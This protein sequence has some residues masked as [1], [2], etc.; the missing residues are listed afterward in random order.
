MQSSIEKIGKALFAH[1]KAQSSGLNIFKLQNLKDFLLKFSIAQP[2]LKQKLFHFVDVLPVLKTKEQKSRF[3][4]EYLLPYL[5]QFIYKNKFFAQTLDLGIGLAV[6]VMARSFICGSNLSQAKAKIKNL[7]DQGLDYTIDILGELALTQVEAD[8]Y[9]NDYIELIEGLEQASISV[10]LSAL[11]P[12]VN[13]LDYS[14]K[15]S[16][17]KKLLREIYRKATEHHCSITVDTEH[18]SWKEMTYELIQELL[19]EDEFRDWQGAGIVLQAYLRESKKDFR[20]WLSWVKKRGTPIKVRLVKGAYWDS[21]YALAKQNGFEIPVWEHKV[22]SD[23]NYEELTRELLLNRHYLRPAI[24][25]H[26]IR[27]LAHALDFASE[28]KIKP[29]E[30]E[31]QMLYGMLDPIKQYLVAHGYQC[32]V[33]MPYGELVPGMSY[34][35][36]RLLENTAN[37]S[38]LRQGFLEHAQIDKLLQDPHRVKFETK[39]DEHEFVNSSNIDFSQK[40]N[41]QKFEQA[42]EKVQVQRF[43]IFESHLDDCDRAIAAAIEIAADWN[44]AKPELRA[45]VLQEAAKALE[46]ERFRFSALICL[47]VHKP[48]QEADREVSETIDFLNYYALSSLALHNQDDLISLPGEKNTNQYQAYGPALVVSPWNFPLAL[49]AGMSS[50]ALVMGNP[51]IIKASQ[52]SKCVAH[53]FVSLMQVA[54]MKHASHYGDGLFQLIQGDGRKLGSYL[55]EH[56]AIR[57]IAFTGSNQVGMRLSDIANK[58]RPAKAMIAEMGGKNAIIVDASADPDEV[59]PGVLYSAFAFAGQKCSAC[60]RLIVE[61]AIYDEFRDRLVEAAKSINLREAWDEA[62]SLGP[63]I[64]DKAYKEIMSYIKLAERD[65]KSLLEPKKMPANFISPRIFEGLGPDHKVVQEEIFGPVLVLL[66]ARDIDHALELANNS[67]YGLTGGIYSRSPKNIAKVKQEFQVGNLYI[68]R[69]CTGAVVARQAFGGVKQSSIGFKAG[70]PNY[71]LQFV[72][73]KTISENTMRRGFVAD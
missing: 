11:I 3:F 49:M 67:D 41:R 62:A 52:L 69:P 50:A 27:S 43:D 53:E 18:Y 31:L 68:N 32:R 57:L 20:S 35:V 22:E 13:Q 72:Q 5:P 51:V 10:K 60:S 7:E 15:K 14:G 64:D 16:K 38:F 44:K 12:Q 17:L 33:Y 65:G 21:E 61:E 73:E 58:S 29:E 45:K 40:L 39:S 2:Q 70:G 54:I 30:F 4:A 47:E 63:V 42:L 1:M 9:F 55:A 19:M 26:N 24:A 71:L 23:I 48:W 46:H 6:G 59:I 37:D 25:S 8:K 28:H 66:K 56:S 36:R 34:L